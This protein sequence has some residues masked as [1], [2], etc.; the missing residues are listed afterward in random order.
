MAFWDS[1]TCC[2]RYGTRWPCTGLFSSKCTHAHDESL[3]FP[4]AL[5]LRFLPFF[6]TLT[7]LKTMLHSVSL[8]FLLLCTTFAQ[9]PLHAPAQPHLRRA[10]RRQTGCGSDPRWQPTISAWADGNTDSQLERWWA[11]VLS[12]GP[13][14]LDNALG[15]QFGDHVN[16]FKCGINHFS[17]CAAQGCSGS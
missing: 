16:D 9:S 5:S 8:L 12:K 14:S 2:G 15:R 17:T 3:C 7:K 4:E 6:S 11:D 1:G 10:F 13:Q